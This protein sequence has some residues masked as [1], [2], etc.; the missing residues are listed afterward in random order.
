MVPGDR[1]A[2]ADE[3]HFVRTEDNGGDRLLLFYRLLSLGLRRLLP[4][5]LVAGVFLGE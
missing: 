3:L 2:Y 5:M 4:G 1:R